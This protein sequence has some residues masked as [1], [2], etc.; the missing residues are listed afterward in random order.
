LTAVGDAAY[1]NGWREETFANFGVAF[2]ASMPWF[3]RTL[4]SW[5][6]EILAAGLVV[7]YFEEPIDTE[8]GRPLSLLLT[9]GVNK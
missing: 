5:M 1:T 7:E 8:S 9:C 3:F 4:S 2:P 6:S